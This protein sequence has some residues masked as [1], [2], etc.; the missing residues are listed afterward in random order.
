[1]NELNSLSLIIEVMNCCERPRHKTGVF[2][3]YQADVELAYQA[4]K[5]VAEESPEDGGVLS[6]KWPRK[7]DSFL[8]FK[9]GSIMQFRRASE[10]ARGYAFHK[11]LYDPRIEDE[12][13]YSVIYHT[14]K[15][16]EEQ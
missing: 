14:E 12:I 16:K 11:V 2:L 9:N 10:S 13:L 5:E 15:I 6:C 4:A 7:Y 8:E 3:K 1:M